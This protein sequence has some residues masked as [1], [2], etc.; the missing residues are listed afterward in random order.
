M[1]RQWSELLGCRGRPRCVS[2]AITQSNGGGRMLQLARSYDALGGFG[3]AEVPPRRELLPHRQ[4]SRQ[5]NMIA[6]PIPTSGWLLPVRGAGRSF[7]SHD[8]IGR[9]TASRGRPSSE[10]AA[11]RPGVRTVGTTIIPPGF[12]GQA[13]H[14]QHVAA[15]LPIRPKFP[16][17]ASPLL[18]SPSL[19]LSLPAGQVPSAQV[20]HCFSSCSPLG[21]PAPPA[22]IHRDEKSKALG[23][24][25]TEDE[26][27]GQRAK[28]V[29]SF[30][31][32]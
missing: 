12:P 18:V 24:P 29:R 5:A 30:A 13:R 28:L 16:L 4:A 1:P 2:C 27:N 32:L 7:A 9:H 31:R 10:R 14:T 15:L 17:I 6:R 21:A 26:E 3:R 11:A 23:G 25:R 20:P 22:R 8:A 19:L